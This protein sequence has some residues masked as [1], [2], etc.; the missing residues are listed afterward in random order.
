MHIIR[1][2]VGTLQKDEPS[3]GSEEKLRSISTDK[4]GER[5]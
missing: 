5:Q 3:L 2:A 4:K 1:K